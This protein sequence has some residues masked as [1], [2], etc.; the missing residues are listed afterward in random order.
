M[1]LRERLGGS[2][3][4]PPYDQV[5]R[6]LCFVVKNESAPGGI[7]ILVL[8]HLHLDGVERAILLIK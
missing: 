5:L 6:G 7:R 4:N 1:G 8:G 2:L 3:L